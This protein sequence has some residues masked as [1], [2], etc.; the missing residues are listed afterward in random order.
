MSGCAARNV[1]LANDARVATIERT[2]FNVPHIT[3]SDA[4]T[5]AYGIA[6]AF[7]EDNICMA[8]NHLVTVRG[9]RAAMFGGSAQGLL[10]LRALNNEQID[11][12]VTAHMND[13]ALAAQWG[14]ASAEARSLA[15]GYVAGYNR[16]L[17]DNKEHLPSA[18][19]GREWVTPMTIADYYRVNELSAVQ[20][21]VGAFAD[22]LLAAKPPAAKVSYVPLAPTPNAQEIRA[23][24]KEIGVIDSELGSNAWAF[25]KDVS[26]NASG[27]LL[28]NPH[29]PWV[30]PNRFYLLHL[31][32][33]GALDVMGAS[34]AFGNVV[35]IGFNRDVAWSHTVSTGKRFTLFELTLDAANPTRYVVDGVSEAMTSRVVTIRSKQA[36]GSVKEVTQTIWSSRWGPIIVSPRAGL[37]WTEGV[38]YAIKDANTGNARM[39]DTW[40]AIARATSVQGIRAA[41]ANLGLPWVNTIAADRNGQAMYA[42][43]SVVPD[44]DGEHLQRC[45]ASASAVGLFNA[46]GIA[47]LNGARSD[48]D[49]RR[50]AS[51]PFP[52]ITPATRMP[53]AIR[54]DWVHN[55]NDS[56]FYSHPAQK[57]N[58]ISPMVGND[59]VAR[60]RTRSGLIEIPQMLANGPVNLERVQSQLF[61]NRNLVA[62]MVLPDLLAACADAPNE[63]A[64]DACAALRGW[65]RT[66]DA[67]ARGAILFR[68]FWRLASSIKD[69][70]R[71]PAAKAEPA[72]TPRGLRMSD[73]AVAAKVW[74]ALAAAAK[75]V[76]DAGFA[77]D[78]PLGSVQRA[79]IVDEAI[80]VHG[81]DDLEG[82]LN[83]VGARGSPELSARGIRIDYGTSYV[84]AVTFDNRGPVANAILVYGQSSDPTSAH[85]V[86]QLKRYSQKQ[87]IALPFHR[88]DIVRERIR[89]PLQL[90]R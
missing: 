5:L 50:D 12:F 28:G 27:V 22:A 32:I 51:S 24:M 49:W 39:T 82:I 74:D 11:L 86:D 78:A 8:A 36:D 61:Q 65:N 79:G 88:D 68:E 60:A 9:Q 15:A 43:L 87:W 2:S 81:G 44:V 64:R 37:N 16:F 7:A 67:D 52:G 59:S 42:D 13:A 30:G 57:W 45:R 4:E 21:G 41:L 33:P 72:L 23:A 14:R 66:N 55:S 10:G 20:A 18:C 35:H 85:A 53:V 46:A 40:L 83:N 62:R 1:N 69:V 38:A 48:C 77:L 31:T 90:Q 76:R 84:Q 19:R 25:G 17:A 70:Y 29:F 34:L 6:Y 89:E 47:V 71:E 58:N 80:A 26:E 54:S 56:F 3:A 73:A 63:L 75:K